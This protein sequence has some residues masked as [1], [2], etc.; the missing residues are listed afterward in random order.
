MKM[1]GQI[2]LRRFK[3]LIHSIASRDIIEACHQTKLMQEYLRSHG[4]V[5]SM[6]ID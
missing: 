1:K 4:I 2:L 6:V 3:E 5:C